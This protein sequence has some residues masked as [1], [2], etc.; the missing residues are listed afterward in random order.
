MWNIP[1]LLR[2]RIYDL[3]GQLPAGQFCAEQIMKPAPGPFCAGNGTID[4]WALNRR[5]RTYSSFQEEAP[6]G[7]MGGA[8]FRLL[9][10]ESTNREF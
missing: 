5:L 3:L 6:R 9:S 1:A 2:E 8:L 10:F 4:C 7:G